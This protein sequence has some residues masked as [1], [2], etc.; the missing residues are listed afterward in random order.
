ML[1][2]NN[3]ALDLELGCGRTHFLFERA[4]HYPKRTIIGIEWKY[5]FIAQAQRRIVKEGLS[6]IYALHGNAWFLVPLLFS[7]GTISH[8]FINFPDPWWKGK[9]K[10]RLLLNKI[11]LQVLYMR[12]KP[13]SFILLQT[14]V[15]ELFIYYKNIIHET[16]Y[17]MLDNNLLDNN[18]Y[19]IARARSHREKKCLLDGLP[20]YRGLFRRQ[21]AVEL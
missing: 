6:N 20:I 10:K 18:I 14:D 9:H 4:A 21:D 19:D 3:N 15:Q 2:N 12:T 17:F 16:K 11:F 1:F 8:I 13:D 7:F 5:E